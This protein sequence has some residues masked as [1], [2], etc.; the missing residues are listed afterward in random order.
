MPP[1]VTGK[2]P[3]KKT[4]RALALKILKQVE[5]QSAFAGRLL[6][7]T[8]SKSVLDPRDSRL[9]YE[10]AMGSIRWQ[11][12]LDHAI[13]QL[14]DRPPDRMD[15]TTRCIIRLGAYQLLFMDR[16]PQRAAVNETVSLSAKYAR[17]F[18]NKILRELARKKESLEWPGE[19]ARA[20]ER[21]SINCSH[22]RWLVEKLI[23]EWGEDEA[24]AFC[25]AD[26]DQAPLTIRVNDL[27]TTREGL[28]SQLDK[29]KIKC[30]P[31]E[32]SPFAVI[33]EG[34][35][36]PGELPGFEQGLFA[37]QDEASQLVGMLLG[38]RPGE[39][40]LDACAA[41]GTKS[42][43][44]FQLMEKNGTLIAAD[45]HEKRL[46]L[47]RR[48]ARRL[49]LQGVM[50]QAA[51]LTRPLDFQI[52]RQAFISC[53]PPGFDRI[54]IDAPCSGL[55]TLRRHPEIKWRLQP[56]EIEN[57]A[58]TQKQIVNNL[59]NYLK[60]GGILVYSTCTVTREENDDVIET[61]VSSGEFELE[62]AAEYLP[63]PAGKAVSR[64]VLRTLPH[65]HGT[66]GFTAFR[67]RKTSE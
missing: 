63:R 56:E 18:I 62:D 24:E 11:A 61:L 34:H 7:E 44:I 20:S 8:I 6:D 67:L 42:L 32:L 12:Q 60:P 58:R 39:Y 5:K 1:S 28:I 40:I 38:A 33:M 65:R 26:Q 21:I 3:G 41:P 66:D 30:R 57:M 31:G 47:A 17:G 27:K 55:G 54:L 23:H 35:F 50:L 45:I 4:A 49:G 46:R 14:S 53:R 2:G 52:D 36:T 48:E 37:V 22:P 10:M 25:R 15:P 13:A 29:K 19:E 51:D 64:G 59:K 43:E 16:V 9:L